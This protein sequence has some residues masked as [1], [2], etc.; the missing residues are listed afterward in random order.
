MEQPLLSEQHETNPHGFGAKGFRPSPADN[1]NLLRNPRE[2]QGFRQ[3]E[4]NAMYSHG[5][6]NHESYSPEKQFG[7][8]THDI[9]VPGLEDEFKSAEKFRLTNATNSTIATLQNSGNRAQAQRFKQ[10]QEMEEYGHE[11]VY[12]GHEAPELLPENDY[13]QNQAGDEEYRDL[14]LVNP[15]LYKPASKPPVI[16]EGDWLCPDPTVS[17]LPLNIFSCQNQNSPCIFFRRRE[18]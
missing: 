11:N 14:P 16:R 3:V 1:N 6:Q 12:G 9:V 2:N 5:S 4:S 7:Q 10:E 15:L 18:S 13:L 8:K 17:L